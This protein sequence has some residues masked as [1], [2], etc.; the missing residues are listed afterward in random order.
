[1]LKPAGRE[2]EV[3]WVDGIVSF[4][5][6]SIDEAVEEGDRQ[7]IAS[8][9][10]QDRE[11]PTLSV[12]PVETA[13]LHNPVFINDIRLSEFKQVLSRAGISSEFNAGI[14]WC[15]NGTLALKK[16]ESGSLSL[17]GPMSADYFEIRE[18]LYSQYAMI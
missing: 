8:E 9:S 15:A 4:P 5:T 2:V 13:P 6:E 7:V 18:L 16:Q 14:L 11:M 10:Q 1:M 12:I 17:E 3:A